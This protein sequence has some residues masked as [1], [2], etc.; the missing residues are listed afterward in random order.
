MKAIGT[1]ALLA[2]A[3]LAVAMAGVAGAPV[4]GGGRLVVVVLFGASIWLALSI[5]YGI[6]VATG[7]FDGAIRS[8]VAAALGTHVLVGAVVGIS[9]LSAALATGP[10]D[11]LPWALRPLRGWAPWVLPQLAVLAGLLALH[12]P[13]RCRL[14]RAIALLPLLGAAAIVGFAC[15]G[16]AW[17]AASAA[18][19]RAVLRQAQRA[20]A[21]A[22][23]DALVLLEIEGLDVR[24]DLGRLLEWTAA[25]EAPAIRAAALAKIRAHPQ[26]TARLAAMLR[27]EW[28]G[29]ALTFLADN[30]PPDGAALARPV[31]D[32][33]LALAADIGDE[34][35]DAHA[36]RA[37]H[38][39]V[40]IARALA[41]VERFEASGVDY[42]PAIGA[43]RAALD[44]PRAAAFEPSCRHLLDRWLANRPPPPAI[45]T[46]RKPADAAIE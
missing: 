44:A 24:T 31:A 9:G 21:A 33:I 38:F 19:D 28:R 17:E 13:L 8:R 35:G 43:L 22:R 12:P 39:D 41:V 16:L 3:V 14:P 2:A 25:G 10:L 42:V 4:A 40:R 30:E 32:A 18:R 15:I 5:G 23:R 11:P 27:G 20:Q 29:E 7:G 34:I 37:D 46:A 6:A 36:L 1:L 45:A 26:L